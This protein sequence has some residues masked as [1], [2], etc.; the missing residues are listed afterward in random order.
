MEKIYV[1]EEQGKWHFWIDRG[2]TFTDVVARAPDG[3]LVVHKVLSHNPGAY[4]DAGLEGIRLCLGL[5]PGLPLPAARIATV[6]M[7][8]TVATNALLERKGEPTL[9]VITTGLKDQLEIG[10]GAADIFAK[11]I[12]KNAVRA[13]WRPTS[14]CAPTGPSGSRSTWPPLQA[15]FA[16]A[17]VDGISAVAIVLMLPTPIRARQQAA[18]WRVP[19]ASRRSRSAMRSRR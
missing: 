15:H 14:A 16:Q 2:G 7:G 19:P 9:L 18:S 8:T 5:A 4:A 10:T 3:R 17:R 1:A 12:V 11:Q 6:K 13:W